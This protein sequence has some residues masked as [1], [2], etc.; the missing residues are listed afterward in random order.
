MSAETL[1]WAMSVLA[2]IT[3]VIAT[4]A[5]AAQMLFGIDTSRLRPF[6]HFMLGSLWTLLS[7]L[8]V[9]L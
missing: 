8:L 9:T 7:V 5:H 4:F 3:M 1:A 6:Y 2:T